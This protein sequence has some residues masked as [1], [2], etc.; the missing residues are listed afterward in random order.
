MST[1]S[2][3]TPEP[4]ETH[5]SP[6]HPTT[7]ALSPA[8][9]ADE[10]RSLRRAVGLLNLDRSRFILAV[11]A[12]TAGMA[13]AVSLS[14]VAAWL[15]ARAS[16]MPDVVALGVA[17]VAVMSSACA[18]SRMMETT[19]WPAATSSGAVRRATL[20]WPPMMT[21]RDMTILSTTRDLRIFPAS[22]NRR[23]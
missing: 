9:S 11:V 7:S 15:I 18:G 8:L 22:T 13:S 16:P 23:A 4:P 19:S 2:T 3:L 6:A 5:V 21:M 20:P 1:A 14:G 10:R 12:G 17:P